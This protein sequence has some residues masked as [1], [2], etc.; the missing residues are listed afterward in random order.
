MASVSLSR[1]RLARLA[2]AA[3]LAAAGPARAD[4]VYLSPEDFL[5]EVFGSP[6]KPEVFRLD[7]AAQ[8]RLTAI[9]GHP[10]RQAR[11]R[12]WR[13]ADK[14]AWIL[15]ETGKEFP[16]TAGFVV[17]NHA[18]ERARVLVYRES[19]GMEVRYPAF[20]RQ[21]A[22]ASL[23]GDKLSKSIDGISGASLSVAAM[24]HMARAALA[25]DEMAR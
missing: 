13:G 12:Y 20:V 25:L 5:R 16:I 8:A 10:Y 23:V 15:D 17:Q 19:R 2:L 11:L 24:E 3:L 4:T 9:L 14:T 1:R 18:I 22:G 6:P 7:A 21:F